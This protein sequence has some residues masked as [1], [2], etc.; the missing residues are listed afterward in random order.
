M[1]IFRIGR[2]I[3][4]NI[5]I[6]YAFIRLF[7]SARWSAA[8]VGD[9]ISMIDD[10]VNPHVLFAAFCA[11]KIYILGKQMLVFYESQTLILSN[12]IQF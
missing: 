11:C 12:L 9:V 10:H 7:F 8:K 2:F 1:K 5:Y 4:Y 3:R 6:Y